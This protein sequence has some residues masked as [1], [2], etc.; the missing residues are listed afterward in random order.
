MHRTAYHVVD[1]NRHPADAKRLANNT[2]QHLGLEMMH[3][4]VK[5]HHIKPAV[6]KRK[7]HGIRDNGCD[8]IS[9]QMGG[10]A[11]EQSDPKVHALL[12]KPFA[13]N[14]RYLTVAGADFQ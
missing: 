9:R 14:H 7:L 4:E 2:L 13:G 3:D 12:R 8:S 1:E 11:I 5:S 10:D 6:A